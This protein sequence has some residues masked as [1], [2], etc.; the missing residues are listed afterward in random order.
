[1]S[2]GAETLELL[3]EGGNGVSLADERGNEWGAGPKKE[4]RGTHEVHNLHG[5]NS[6]VS[7]HSLDDAARNVVKGGEDFTLLC[8]DYRTKIVSLHES[9]GSREHV[10]GWDAYGSGTGTGTKPF[11]KSEP[12]PDAGEGTG[13]YGR[14]DEVDVTRFVACGGRAFPGLPKQ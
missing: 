9:E 8:V 11:A 14:S 6:S 10:Q 13:S 12:D 3:G 4:A 1:M 7:G 2:V 5:F